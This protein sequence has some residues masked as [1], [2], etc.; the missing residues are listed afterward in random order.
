MN[1][2]VNIF[3]DPPATQPPE[4]KYRSVGK[5][6]F[7][8]TFVAVFFSFLA[9]VMVW[10]ALPIIGSPPTDPFKI[11]L[12]YWLL[13]IFHPASSEV[14]WYWNAIDHMPFWAVEGRLWLAGV[15]GVAI[16]LYV[17]YL[18]SIPHD[19]L[20]HV[21]G[22]RLKT[23]KEAIKEAEALTKAEKDSIFMYIH[24]KFGMPKK[25]WTRHLLIYGGVGSGKTV[26]QLFLLQQVFKQNH[27]AIIYDI[28][29]DFTAKFPSALLVSPWDKRSAVWDIAHDIDTE[30][31]SRTFGSSLFPAKEGSDNAYFKNGA[32]EIMIALIR[33]LY[34]DFEGNW[35][36]AE[37]SQRVSLPQQK[38]HE[39]VARFNSSQAELI[40][41]KE[42]KTALSV[43][44]T[45]KIGTL[46]ITQ[47]GQAW[48]QR[49][50]K[51]ERVSLKKWL[52]DDYT[53]TRQIIL[54]GGKDK[55]FQSAYISAMINSLVP[56]IISPAF[57]DDEL[58]R[59]LFFFIDEFP[60]IGKID[61]ENIV[62]LGRSKGGMVILGF[63][64]I[65]QVKKIYGEEFAHSLSGMTAN[66]IVCQLGP[67]DT[68]KKVAEQIGKRRVAVMQHNQTRGGGGPGSV[69]TSYNEQERALM[70]ETELTT[71][72]GTSKEWNGVRSL[73]LSGKQILMLDF[74]F[75]KLPD[76]RPSFVEADWCKSL[77]E[78]KPV[79]LAFP[80]GAIQSV[81]PT[82]TEDSPLE[83][84]VEQVGVESIGSAADV[85]HGLGILEELESKDMRTKGPSFEVRPSFKK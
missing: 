33:S 9:S 16:G 18:I 80:A 82:I 11:H 19:H 7:G 83:S 61:I 59:S 22:I 60:T 8:A 32:I 37:L 14:D 12:G 48:G 6:V 1:K 2:I 64:D 38:L 21:K 56:E 5:M 52:R 57:K 39:Y 30:S 24:P 42:S 72:L 45:F 74:P 79:A 58:G 44:N 46:V 77:I 25:R 20:I 85:L 28:K 31:S 71:D 67:G 47:L 76:Q 54:Q 17:G 75:P 50:M 3:W 26:I 23:G 73:I 40:E 34:Y 27:K 4:V 65:A 69:S 81:H 43:I 29:G 62:A 84:V 51:R 10:R 41:D 15:L 78:N 36:W 68:R 35:G 49:D 63:Q 66:H 53:G 70:I 13:T 55:V